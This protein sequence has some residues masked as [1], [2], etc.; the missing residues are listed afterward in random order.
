MCNIT[1]KA[2]LYLHIQIGL[3]LIGIGDV[4]IQA[5]RT[6]STKVI[7]HLYTER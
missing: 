5:R 7:P 1:S 4:E 3:Y 2:Y 6:R